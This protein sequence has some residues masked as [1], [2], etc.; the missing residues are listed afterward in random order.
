ML[1]EHVEKE[2]TEISRNSFFFCAYQRIWLKSNTV[3]LFK[4]EHPPTISNKK[5]SRAINIPGNALQIFLK[6]YNGA[7]VHVQKRISSF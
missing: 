7:A 6:L 1:Y 5:V 2:N 3:V 4:G